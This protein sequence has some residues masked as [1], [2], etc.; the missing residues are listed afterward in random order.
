MEKV[1]FDYS[2]LAGRITEKFGTRKLF[3]ERLGISES[4]LSMKMSGTFYFSQTEIEK[5]MRL[6]AIEPGTVSDYFFT[7]KV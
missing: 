2:K 1:L 5:S 3:A 4:T 7:V 6:L